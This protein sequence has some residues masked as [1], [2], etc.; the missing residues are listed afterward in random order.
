MA[1]PRITAAGV[2]AEGKHGHH[3]GGSHGGQHAMRGR[4]GS[5]SRGAE[6]CT[7]GVESTLLSYRV[8]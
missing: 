7:T 4:G 1:G 8:V 2:T 6:P 5:R 3:A